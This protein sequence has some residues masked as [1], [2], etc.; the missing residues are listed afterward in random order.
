M[1]HIF[2]DHLFNTIP[3]SYRRSVSSDDEVL[4]DSI[5]LSRIKDKWQES[6][7]V[8][9][10]HDI[11][12]QSEQD[13]SN[14]FDEDLSSLSEDTD[15]TLCD[16]NFKGTCQMKKCLSEGTKTCQCGMLVCIKHYSNENCEHENI[17]LNDD[18]TEITP[19]RKRKMKNTL[20][21]TIM[22]RN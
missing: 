20:M 22:K 13:I 2:I 7:I 3:S 16:P 17:K 1:I 8:K 6:G 5:P 11:S 18:E 19:S 9:V 10:E 14:Q 21:A 4:I 15:D 12:N